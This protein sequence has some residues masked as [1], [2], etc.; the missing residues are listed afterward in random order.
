MKNVTTLSEVD[1]L[2]Y[3]FSQ[4]KKTG[5]ATFHIIVTIKMQVFN[6]F[7]AG[8]QNLRMTSILKSKQFNKKKQLSDDTHQL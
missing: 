4:N 3:I 8:N 2:H 1:D 6:I 7:L 5:S